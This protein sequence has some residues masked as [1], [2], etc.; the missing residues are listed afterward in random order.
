LVFVTVGTDHH[1]FDRLMDWTDSWL[2]RNA[3]HVRSLVQHGTSRAPSLGEA[4]D[5]L[6]QEEMHDAMAEAAAIVTHGGPGTIAL[7]RSL[8]K[9]PIVVARDP[10]LGEHVDDHQILFTQRMATLRQIQQARSEAE[11]VSLLDRALRE[12]PQAVAEGGDGVPA[13]VTRFGELVDG[14]F[15]DGAKRTRG[16]LRGPARTDR[17]SR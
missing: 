7:S 16:W 12:G 10:A 8:G 6:S 17:S 13:A 1:P 3:G 15:T 2:R 4:R 5:Y 14:L 11:L 9:L